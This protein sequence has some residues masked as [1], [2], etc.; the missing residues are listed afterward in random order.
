MAS[1]GY[2][3]LMVM[4][5][6]PRITAD[7]INFLVIFHHYTFFLDVIPINPPQP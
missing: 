6:K 2:V 7:L 5:A 3:M 4:L 1:T